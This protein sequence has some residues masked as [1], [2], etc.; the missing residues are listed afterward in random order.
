MLEYQVS[1]KDDTK[2]TNQ[3]DTQQR[4]PAQLAGEKFIILDPRTKIPIHKW[5]DTEYQLTIENTQKWLDAGYNYGVLYQTDLAVLDAD[6]A[7]RLTEC[8]L[9]PRLQ[10]TF[11]VN[12][13]RTNSKG[14]H[15]YFRISGT[16]PAHLTGKKIVFLDSQHSDNELGDIRL[17][18]SK[19]Y[20]VGPYSTHPTGNKYLPVDAEAAIRTIDFEEL[21]QTIRDC[22]SIKEPKS[23]NTTAT[24]IKTRLF[25]KVATST[26]LNAYGFTCFDFLS[27]LN[28]QETPDNIVGEHPVH[29]STT[30]T[31]LAVSKDGSMWYCRRCGTGGNWIKA[32]AVSYGIIDC[33]DA[34]RDLTKAEWHKVHNVLRML[35]PDIY[36]QN[37]LAY[38][39][40]KVMKIMQKKSAGECVCQK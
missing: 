19:F 36:E 7:E 30:G 2:K 23:R 22:V 37:W 14:Q 21:Y 9:L 29:S 1:H 8:G 35:R 18:G 12:S 26:D 28:P 16:I 38:Q 31:N 40:E 32:L 5:S 4:I 10:P 15:L 3:T 13:G 17:P 20:N 34:G 11:T 33:S 39:Q 24:A 6:N 25:N 27:P